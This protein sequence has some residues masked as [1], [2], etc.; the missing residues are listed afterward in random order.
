MCTTETTVAQYQA[1]GMGYLA[2]PFPQRGDHPAVDVSKNDANEWCTRLSRRDGYNY[3]L[4]KLAEWLAAVGRGTYPW[5]QSW[6]PPNHVGNYS[7][8]EMRA[9]TE[10]E[11][12]LLYEGYEL[13]KGF[14]DGHKFTSPVG[15]Y[16]PNHLGIHDLGGNVWEW[17]SD[18]H[19]KLQ[20]NLLLR[21]GAWT[22]YGPKDLASSRVADT[23]IPKH[24]Y[25][26]RCV[27][28]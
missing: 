23:G 9:A 12:K 25:G 13:I 17:G 2:P 26:F 14:R 8:Q 18:E 19:D 3:R 15:S 21:G 22:E 10:A 5:G 20:G 28:G 24:S 16:P 11:R 1:A 27:I 4:P 6:P 7:G